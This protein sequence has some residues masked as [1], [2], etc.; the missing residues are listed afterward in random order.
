M[1][2]LP[3]PKGLRKKRKV[4][5]T[6]FKPGNPGGPGRPKGLQNKFTRDMK[7]AFFEAFNELGGKDWLVKLG[8]VD[9]R[10]FAALCSRLLPSQI[11][12]KDGGPIQVLTE[13]A[14]IGLSK[15]TDSELE[16]LTKLLNKIGL[17]LDSASSA[18]N[19]EPD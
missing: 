1:A 19:P 13:S 5:K 15:L 8:K 17:D 7:E 16:S 9:R 18:V 14:Q 2:R 11:T 4:P 10:A 6:A 3:T 12:G